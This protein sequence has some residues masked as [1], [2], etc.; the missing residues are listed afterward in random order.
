MIGPTALFCACE[1]GSSN[2]H[3]SVNDA[4][5]GSSETQA[6]GAVKLPPV[7]QPE[8][9]SLVQEYTKLRSSLVVPPA[10][11]GRVNAMELVWLV[12]CVEPM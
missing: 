12:S 1:S 7:I 8:I 6:T 11:G 4:L 5:G 2:V 10:V 9:S 3:V